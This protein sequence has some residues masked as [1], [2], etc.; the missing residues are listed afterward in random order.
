MILWKNFRIAALRPYASGLGKEC[1][2]RYAICKRKKIRFFI[3]SGWPS[4]YLTRVAMQNLIRPYKGGRRRRKGW[5]FAF[6]LEAP[7]LDLMMGLMERRRKYDNHGLNLDPNYILYHRKRP[8]K[9]RRSKCVQVVHACIIH[10][11]M[12]HI[13]PMLNTLLKIEDTRDYYWCWQRPLLRCQW[14]Y[15]PFFQLNQW[16]QVSFMRN[17]IHSWLERQQPFVFKSQSD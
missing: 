8:C 1:S 11:A 3:P 13:A 7:L 9:G 6:G 4:S 14:L 12:Y 2:L 16:G 17:V 5:N 10:V 15:L